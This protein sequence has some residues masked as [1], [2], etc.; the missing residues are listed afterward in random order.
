MQGTALGCAE[1]L[2]GLSALPFTDFV[3][4]RGGAS[5]AEQWPA[6]RQLRRE[7]VAPIKRR[8]CISEEP[9]TDAAVITRLAN[10]ATFWAVS[11]HVH[12][13]EWQLLDLAPAARKRNTICPDCSGRALL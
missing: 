1:A 5:P 7:S 11:L 6:A 8:P 4:A 12:P 2:L 13:A 9:H 10:T 3:R